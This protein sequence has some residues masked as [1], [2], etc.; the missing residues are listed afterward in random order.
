MKHLI[1]LLIPLFLMSCSE[2]KMLLKS[3]SKYQVPLDY[4]H[5]SRI[6]DC[7]K[8]TGITFAKF[9]NQVFDTSTSVTKIN[10]RIL[11]FIFY[12]YTEVNLAVKLGQSSL[13]QNYSDFFKNAFIAESQ[14][15]GCYS[16]TDDPTNSKYTIEIIFDTCNVNSKYQRSSTVLFL[17]FAYSMHFQERGFPAET[18]LALNVRL[19]KENEL[20]FEERYSVN[21]VQP[22]LNIPTPNVNRLRS[23]FVTN[24]A[25]SL[26]LGTK[27]SIEQ[28]ITD[29]NQ[30]IAK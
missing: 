12:N 9:D 21:N 26:S 13:E 10:Q 14:R 28:I 30:V 11:P 24:M 2:S 23:N 27:E 6:N 15:T 17:L 3:L 22:F 19:K 16:L 1:F 20:I 5:D 7:D 25:E 4:L 8:T 29:I 18:N